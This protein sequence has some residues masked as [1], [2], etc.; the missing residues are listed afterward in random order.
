MNTILFAVALLALC[1]FAVLKPRYAY[2][3]KVREPVVAGSFYPCSSGELTAM[4][5]KY[6]ADA[7]EKELQG[8]LVALI[9]PHAGYVFSGHVAAYAYKQLQGK[10]I[11]T[12]VLIGPSHRYLVRGV[13]VYDSGAFQTPLGTVEVN[14]ELA[15]ELIKQERRITSA[16]EAHDDEHCLEVHLPFLQRVLQSFKIVPILMYDFSD[17]NCKMLSQALSSCLNRKN[18]LLVA[19]T[20]LCHYPSYEE[21]KKADSIVVSAISKFDPELLRKETDEYMRRPIR[22]LHCMLCGTGAVITVMQAA[23]AL[24]AN[25]VEI[26]KYANSGDVPFGDKSQVVGYLAAAIYKKT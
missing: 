25:A 20:D 12:V 23:K 16:P 1:A 18:A 2:A 19:S 15:S 7:G 9:A 22:N 24:G 13:A 17:A 4:V 3:A 21:A 14:E 26:L 8:E 5:D 11:E 6:L 10:S